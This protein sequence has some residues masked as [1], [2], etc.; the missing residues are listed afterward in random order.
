MY[1]QPISENQPPPVD[2]LRS[3]VL[4]IWPA[5]FSSQE[6]ER[7]ATAT[8]PD[9][10]DSAVSRF[11]LMPRRVRLKVEETFA[12]PRPGRFTLY[13]GLSGGDC[14]ISFK[15][16]QRW[17]VDAYLDDAGRWIARQCSVTLPLADA[18]AVLE[19]LRSQQR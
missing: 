12:G 6:K 7:I 16:G 8:S 10:L 11:W 2:Q 1:G 18:Q 9:E 17:L 4:Q 15:V 14:G 19:A 3:F 5:L 13:T